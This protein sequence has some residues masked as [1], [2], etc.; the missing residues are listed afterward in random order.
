MGE[1]ASP[2]S[3]IIFFK[4]SMHNQA[5]YGDG[6]HQRCKHDWTDLSCARRFG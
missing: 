4:R 2:G 3:A 6:V 5:L 1:S